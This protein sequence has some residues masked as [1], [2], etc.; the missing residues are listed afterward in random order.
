MNFAAAKEINIQMIKE[1]LEEGRKIV[2]VRVIVTF[3]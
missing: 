1:K 2:E 3:I